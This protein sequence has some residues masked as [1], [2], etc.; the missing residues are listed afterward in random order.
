MKYVIALFIIMASFV[1]IGCAAEPKSGRLS[2]A[3]VQSNT[4][5]RG[6]L[7]DRSL[8]QFD[9]PHLTDEST[10]A[11][12]LAFAAL[13]NPGLKERFLN[14]TAAVEQVPQAGALPDPQ[15]SYGYFIREV[16]TRV[17]PQ[18]HRLGIMQ[19]FP[20]FGTLEA[21]SDA[22]S[23][24]AKAAGQR[25]EAAK[26]E[27][28]RQVTDAY[29]EY[30]YLGS[31]IEIAAANVELLE[32]FE[33]VA[34]IQYE[35]GRASFADVVRAQ[36]ELAV[37]EDTLRGLQELRPARAGRL[38][39]ILGRDPAKDLPWPVPVEPVM[40]PLETESVIAALRERN[41]DLE[42][43]RHQI[44]AA[45]H[46]VTL[47]QKRSLPD[48]SVG[49]DWIQTGSA[50]MA[51]VPNSGKDPVILMFSMNL[52]LWQDSYAAGRRQARAQAAAQ[53]RGRQEAENRLISQAQDSLYEYNDSRR[54][55]RLYDEV[56]LPRAEEL[57]E[58]SKTGYQAAMVDFI[59]LIDAQ[60]LLLQYE[61]QYIRA[62]ADNIQAVAAI[63][64]LAGQNMSMLMANPN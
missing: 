63:E 56:L 46:E 18:Q 14:Y 4:T 19:R 27:L 35:A 44:E 29:A 58:A 53:R 55:L 59:G 50:R 47:A 37:L 11:D 1:V 38:N 49:V 48:F 51:D 15:L 24:R 42:A 12:Y 39:A 62:A 7:S 52:P 28:F 57:L 26:L 20:W 32:H 22:A 43:L 17:G 16:E 21:R 31:S 2:G 3:L 64:R 61:L 25:F 8:R 9:A 54:K 36:L 41:P 30:V 10:L 6:A 5:S 34:L 13:N 60:R 33:Q 45:E 40:E 23:Q